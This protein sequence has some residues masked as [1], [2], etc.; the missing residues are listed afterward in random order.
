[1]KHFTAN[2]LIQFLNKHIIGQES[3]KQTLSVL[4]SNKYNKPDL[5]RQMNHSTML[6]IGPAGIGKASLVKAAAKFL[7]TP[8]ARISSL[9]L[10]DT[11][12]LEVFERLITELIEGVISH[13]KAYWKNKYANNALQLSKDKII[14]IIS[15]ITNDS[16]EKIRRGF[17][18][19]KYDS[20]IIPIGI[21]YKSK[22][23]S[24][25]HVTVSD[26]IMILQEQEL[27]K[28]ISLHDFAY[29]AINEAQSTGIIIIDDL[30][31]LA[32]NP[33]NTHNISYSRQLEICQKYITE[34]I[35]GM[36][37][38]TKYGT[39]NT[40]HLLCICMGYFNETHVTHLRPELQTHLMN[41]AYCH[42]LTSEDMLLIL[43]TLDDTILHKYLEI[44]QDKNI[45]ITFDTDAM[46][47]LCDCAYKQ[48][49]T[50]TNLG[51][52]RLYSLL[53]KLFEPFFCYDAPAKPRYVTITT[54]EI[55]AKFSTY[56]EIFDSSRYIL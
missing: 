28:M 29:E 23:G 37:L 13:K 56:E 34:F 48:N 42:D 53:D 30:D 26:A 17:N 25:T 52:M 18:K 3:A 4:L 33:F 45:H 24:N 32:I 12:T 46:S 15:H 14:E 1:M 49:H 51:I 2:E 47:A 7:Q 55:L 39:I 20:M 36:T 9:S 5:Y 21:Y 16:I 41:I 8:I 35:T 50:S 54:E 40:R 38:S 6:L 43:T 10:L 22:I 31:K 44:L 27:E 19:N 11:H